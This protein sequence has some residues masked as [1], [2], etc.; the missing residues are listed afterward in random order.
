M[1]DNVQ[2]QQL[3]ALHEI[4]VRNWILYIEDLFNQN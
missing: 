4:L 3:I 2:T 1:E